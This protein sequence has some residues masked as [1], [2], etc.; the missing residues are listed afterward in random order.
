MRKRLRPSDALTNDENVVNQFNLDE[1]DEYEDD[2][3]ANEEG[4]DKEDDEEAEAEEEDHIGEVKE[5]EE[6]EEEEG[7]EKEE[8]AEVRAPAP[9]L[10]TSSIGSSVRPAQTFPLTI[11]VR[12]G[13]HQPEGSTLAQAP[14]KVIHTLSLGEFPRTPS[15]Q[16][17]IQEIADRLASEHNAHP[18]TVQVT[19]AAMLKAKMKFICTHSQSSHYMCVCVGG[20]SSSE[21]ALQRGE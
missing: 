18:E 20:R 13:L 17:R 10:P 8:G 19:T 12:S 21:P 5:E 2:E 15:P 14:T 3:Q 7:K 4:E 1:E 6:E 11:Q 16:V 9:K